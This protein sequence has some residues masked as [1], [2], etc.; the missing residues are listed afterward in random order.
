MVLAIGPGLVAIVGNLPWASMTILP[1][2]VAS[3]GELLFG[4][5]AWSLDGSGA[6]WRENLPVSPSH[7]FDARAWVITEFLTAAALITIGMGALRAGVPNESE[8]AAL[9]CTL[10]VVLLQV[11]GA[12][13]RWS[14][15]HP[16]PADLRSARATPAPPVAM[17]GYSARLAVSTTF[18]SLF[19]SACAK[20]P[21]WQLSLIVAIPCVMWSGV[22]LVRTARRWEDPMV[23]A[24]VVTTTA[25]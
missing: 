11:V 16:Y 2:L 4:V 25:A 13:M 15:A 3:G 23:R 24:R 19:F 8:T 10:V 17:V 22:R 6:L 20:A 5:N 21:D 1:G 12:A 9:L 14:I 7:V 18:T